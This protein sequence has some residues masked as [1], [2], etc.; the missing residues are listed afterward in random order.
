MQGL[1]FL[2]LRL[3]LGSKSCYDFDEGWGWVQEFR[4]SSQGVLQARGLHLFR[5][6]SSRPPA[7]NV[8]RASPPQLTVYLGKRDFVDHIDL[9]DPVGESLRPGRKA[10]GEAGWPGLIQRRGC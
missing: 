6:V 3:G 2:V 8:P 7:A 9:V 10:S 4:D 1:L 5:D